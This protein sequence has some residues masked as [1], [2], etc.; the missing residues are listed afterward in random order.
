M[1]CQVDFISLPDANTNLYTNF[2]TYK[3]ITVIHVVSDNI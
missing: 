3:N 2:R 1:G